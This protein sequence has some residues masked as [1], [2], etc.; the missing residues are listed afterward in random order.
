MTMNNFD[1]TSPPLEEV[2]EK[3]HAPL[4]GIRII[5]LSMFL[6]GP[7]CTQQLADLGAEIIKIEPRQGDS[8]RV[9]PPHFHHGESLY[10]ISTNRS[11]KGIS[12]DLQS[13]E[14]RKILHRLVATADVVIDNFRPGI[15]KKLEADYDTLQRINPRII[16]CSI[17]GFG[18]DGPYSSRPAYDMIVQALSGGMSITG[19]PGGRPVRAGIPIGDICAGLHAVIGIQAALVE[20]ARSGKGQFIDISM[21]DV[22]VAMLAYQGVYHL[23]SGDVPG[24]Q[25]RGHAS[26]PTYASFQAADKLDVLICANTEKMWASLCEVLELKSLTDDARFLT[27]ELRHQHRNELEPLLNRAFSGQTR[28]EW[29]KRL[30]A[31]N[32]PCA[33]VNTIQEALADPQVR[34]RK[35]VTKIDHRLGGEL[36]IL[37]N[38]IKMSRSPSAQAISP[39]LFGEHTDEVLRAIGCSDEELLQWRK[40]GLIA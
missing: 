17:S 11:K 12:L 27:N 35:M 37:G 1:G 21:L 8:T 34:H 3:A 5:D 28:E 4:N 33:P 16:C 32:V 23:F 9:L 7:Y 36:E 39:P 2:S 14:G 13:P 40:Q 30:N 20:R 18:Q 26:I 15:M 24:G 19:E 22:Q 10:F 31:H 38:P 6:A 29:L 25:G